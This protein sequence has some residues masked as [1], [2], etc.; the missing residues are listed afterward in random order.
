MDFIFREKW[1]DGLRAIEDLCGQEIA[2][3]IL[4]NCVNY[5]VN[6]EM[7]SDNRAIQELVLNCFSEDSQDYIEIPSEFQQSHTLKPILDE[8]QK[9]V[10]IDLVD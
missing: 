1:F 9:L 2:R 8:N 3:E 6:T 10:P 7:T 5:M 4:W